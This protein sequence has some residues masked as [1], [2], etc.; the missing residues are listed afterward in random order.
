MRNQYLIKPIYMCGWMNVGR[1]QIIVFICTLSSFDTPGASWPPGALDCRKMASSISQIINRIGTFHSISVVIFIFHYLLNAVRSHTIH[2]KPITSVQEKQNIQTNHRE[3]HERHE[4]WP[5]RLDDW[6]HRLGLHPPVQHRWDCHLDWIAPRFDPQY[7]RHWRGTK[8]YMT[9][10]QLHTHNPQELGTLWKLQR[11][12]IDRVIL[13]QA[14]HHQ[15]MT[16]SASLSM[17]FSRAC[18]RSEVISTSA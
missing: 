14:I 8:Y 7:P 2:Q 17:K 13:K 3:E 18:F 10:G 5:K 11:L 6:E 4:H 12:I 15:H 1:Y 16:I 9:R